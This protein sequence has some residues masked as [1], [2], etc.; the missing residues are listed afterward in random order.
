[1]LLRGRLFSSHG[2]HAGCCYFAILKIVLGNDD[3]FFV[4]CLCSSSDF[5]IRF[6]G[7]L[8]KSSALEV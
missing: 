2:K 7:E 8:R 6:S 4:N 1:M 5:I 3:I